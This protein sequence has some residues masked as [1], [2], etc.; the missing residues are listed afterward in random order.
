[1]VT[2]VVDLMMAAMFV[3]ILS[4]PASARGVIAA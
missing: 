4:R 3:A 1:L 2:G